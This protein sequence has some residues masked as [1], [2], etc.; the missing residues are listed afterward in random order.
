MCGIAAIL[1]RDQQRK[2]VFM[3]RSY[4]LLHHRG[5]DSDGYW[6]DDLVGLVHKRL[7]IQDLTEAGNQ[8]MVSSG[9]RYIIIFN[10]EIYNHLELRT[11]FFKMKNGG[12]ILIQKPFWHYLKKLG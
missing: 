8:P 7:S 9:G 4:Q 3:E 1:S 6:K 10:G 5:P 12:D 11:R 2:D